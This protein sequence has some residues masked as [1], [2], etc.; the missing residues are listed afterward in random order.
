MTHSLVTL[1]K[2]EES[3][4][5][6]GVEKHPDNSLETDDYYPRRLEEEL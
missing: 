6:Q 1:L 3:S 2:R 4:M 5:I